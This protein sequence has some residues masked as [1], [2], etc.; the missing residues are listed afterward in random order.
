MRERWH[1]P[2]DRTRPGDVAAAARD[3]MDV[4]LRYYIAER[5]DV[6]L[7]ALG[8]LFQGASDAGDFG[9]QLRLLD[10]VEI[11]D[12]HGVVPARYQQQPWVMRILDHQHTAQRQVADV[13]GVFLELRMQRPGGIVRGHKGS[14]CVHRFVDGFGLK[15]LN[16]HRPQCHI[17]A[18]SSAKAM[19]RYSPVRLFIAGAR[20]YRIP[21][22][23]GDDGRRP[24]CFPGHLAPNKGREIGGGRAT[25][26]P[27]QVRKEA[28]LTRSGSGRSSVSYP[29]F[30]ANRAKVDTLP[31]L[32]LAPVI[33]PAGFERQSS[34]DRSM[35]DAGAPSMPSDEPE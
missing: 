33:P 17:K 30:R 3:N 28:A 6:E 12:L 14:G 24:A 19:I 15:C 18:S 21:G 8:D 11:D 13:D 31:A 5:C 27:G 22:F 9:H 23:G 10:L 32:D 7:V 35:T 25:R 16:G 20:V 2:P 4:Q 1:H 34:A 26:Q 29:F